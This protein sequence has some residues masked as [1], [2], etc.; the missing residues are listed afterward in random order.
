MPFCFNSKRG[1]GHAQERQSTF[2]WTDA[3]TNSPPRENPMTSHSSAAF[4]KKLK[5]LFS[6]RTDWLCR[7]VRQPSAGRPPKFHKKKIDRSI[8]EL[9]SL[10]TEFLCKQRSIKKLDGLYRGKK[11]WQV[12]SNKGW[13]RDKKQAR[14]K[15]WYDQRIG[16]KNC[17]YVFWAGKKCKYVGST[18]KGKNR[19]Q[20]HFIKHW[21][22][23][24]K[25]VDI[26]FCKGARNISKLECLATHLFNPSHS[27][28]KPAARKMHS[29]CPICQTH[30]NIRQEVK[31][32]FKLK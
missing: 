27:K 28:I 1:V 21:F 11:K 24:V 32:I 6:D 26:Y 9:Q 4:N 19:P 14:F 8:E 20:S 30:R 7:Q 12:N 17:V 5:T 13:G 25:R 22:S 15:E 3:T 23:S 10:A 2:L 18:K 31:S 29:K 16:F